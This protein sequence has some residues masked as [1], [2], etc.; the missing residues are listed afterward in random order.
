MT[1]KRKEAS[2]FIQP[3]SRACARAPH[4]VNPTVHPSLCAQSWHPVNT[5]NK[6]SSWQDTC[7]CSSQSWE[8]WWC[9]VPQFLLGW[10][11]GWCSRRCIVDSC[12]W[13]LPSPST[14][15]R[16][17]WQLLQTFTRG[18]YLASTAHLALT[19][20]VGV[21]GSCHLR[22]TCNQGLLGTWWG[23]TRP[24]T[25][26]QVGPTLGPQSLCLAR[27]CCRKEGTTLPS[28]RVSV[29]QAQSQVLCLLCQEIRRKK[30]MLPI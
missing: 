9:L 21:P 23:N 11:W 28:C 29:V 16:F 2:I 27:L 30:S 8:W 14:P 24:L 20:K 17:P 26:W 4:Q 7:V 13:V 19:Q 6:P 22:V 12:P 18:F 1:F 3:V 10:C 15:G 5:E 25:H